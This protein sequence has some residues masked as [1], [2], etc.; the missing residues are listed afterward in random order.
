MN[1]VNDIEALKARINLHAILPVLEELERLDRTYGGSGVGKARGTLVMTVAGAPELSATLWFKGGGMTV[2]TEKWRRPSL[3]L[4]FGSP[5][6]L[7][8]SFAGGK[9]RPKIKGII[10]LLLLPKFMKMSKLL[11]KSLQGDGAPGGVKSRAALLLRVVVYAM[12]ILASHHN[13][14]KAMIAGMDGTMQFEIAP[15]GP[16]Y[17]ITIEKGKMAVYN[18]K[19]SAPKSI[20]RWDD[21]ETAV[22]VLSGTMQ[23][24]DAIAQ[25]KMHAIGD[26]GF[27]LQV[28]GIMNKVGEILRP[29]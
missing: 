9:E 27:A 6:A 19:H 1:S 21:S 28:G 15:A 10:G 29:K 18:A 12:E 13:E 25:K 26:P 2:V 23:A 7:N 20:I 14:V 17:H 22:A 5:K 11:G 4:T 8:D 3:T 24:M 16:Y